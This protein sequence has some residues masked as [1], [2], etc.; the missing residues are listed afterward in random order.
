VATVAPALLASWLASDGLVEIIPQVGCRVPCTKARTSPT[1]SPYSAERKAL[2][3]ALQPSGS[4]A[5][6]GELSSVNAEIGLLDSDPDPLARARGYRMLNRKKF[7]WLVHEMARSPVVAEISRRM[8]NMSDLL[9]NTS[10]IPQPLASAVSVRYDDHERITDA[11][12]E[13]DSAAARREMEAHIV[14]IVA[15]F[16]PKLGAPA[17]VG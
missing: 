2:W 13:N 12:R 11:L 15:I 4:P 16:I 14:G 17:T 3:L 5:Q 9:I 6:L 10:G 7:H 1:S 8:W